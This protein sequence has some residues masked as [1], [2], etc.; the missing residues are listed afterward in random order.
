MPNT[1]HLSLSF[2]FTLSGK[3]DGLSYSQNTFRFKIVRNINNGPSKQAV[4]SDRVLTAKNFMD[5]AY[6]FFEIQL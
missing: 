3:L 6:I 1:V 2:A 5:I 4:L